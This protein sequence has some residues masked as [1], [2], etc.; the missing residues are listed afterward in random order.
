VVPGNLFDLHCNRRLDISHAMT[1]RKHYGETFTAAPHFAHQV[2]KGYD[3]ASLLSI[4]WRMEKPFAGI[5]GLPTGSRTCRR[6]GI[7]LF[8]R[9]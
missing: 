3:Q 9:E 6:S 1:Q 8:N 5:R 2:A 4:F 7:S